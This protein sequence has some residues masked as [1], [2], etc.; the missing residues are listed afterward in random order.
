[1]PKVVYSA[2]KGLYQES[3]SG[4]AVGD[5]SVVEASE[6]I[7]DTDTALESYGTSSID[8]TDGAVAVSLAANTNVGATKFISYDT[9]VSGAVVTVGYVNT[10]GD[11][12]IQLTFDAAGE[13][14]QLISNG[15]TW[16]CVSTTATEST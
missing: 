12:K 5:V 6:S 11:V 10:S 16:I 14:A 7:T 3:G 8:S 2:S 13:H 1:M 4:F 9:H 15:T